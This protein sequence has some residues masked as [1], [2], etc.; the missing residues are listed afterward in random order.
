MTEGNLLRGLEILNPYM[1]KWDRLERNGHQ[2]IVRVIYDEVEESEAEK[3]RELGWQAIDDWW[4]FEE[5]NAFRRHFND[6]FDEKNFEEGEVD[7][8]SVALEAMKD[9]ILIGMMDKEITRSLSEY[10]HG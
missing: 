2:N 7:I 6:W 5:N 4:G 1:K 9:G 3:L 10:I 8:E